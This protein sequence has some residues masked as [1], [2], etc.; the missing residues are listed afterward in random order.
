MIDNNEESYLKE[1]LLFLERRITMLTGKLE[2][3]RKTAVQTRKEMWQ[4]TTSH[5]CDFD[6]V[7]TLSMQNGLVH[8]KDEDYRHTLAEIKQLRGLLS[9][10]YFG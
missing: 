3:K 8:E 4:E 7:V 1:V 6:D 5:I 2:G 9:S 10:P